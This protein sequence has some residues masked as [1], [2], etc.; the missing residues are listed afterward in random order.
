MD[1]LKLSGL[2]CLAFALNP[3][4]VS[5]Q[6]DM[7]LLRDT[8]SLP[9]GNDYNIDI[10]SSKEL[11]YDYIAETAGN[12][13]IGIKVHDYGGNGIIDRGFWR[14]IEIY[15]GFRRF[16]VVLYDANLRELDRQ[17]LQGTQGTLDYDYIFFDIPSLGRYFVSIRRDLY[18]RDDFMAVRITS[19]YWTTDE[20]V[21]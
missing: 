16:N 20:I 13:A 8:E 18:E 1:N 17:V 21:P 11:F 10:N 2:L 14:G 5:A 15:E 6:V 12:L 3:I 4:M 9:I 19:D 7:R